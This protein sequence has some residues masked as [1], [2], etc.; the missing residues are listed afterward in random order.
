MEELKKKLYRSNSLP[1]TDKE[2]EA[3]TSDTTSFEGFSRID[4]ETFESH[5]FSGGVAWI[6]ANL[7][8]TQEEKDNYEN[9]EIN[10]LEIRIPVNNDEVERLHYKKLEEE[11]RASRSQSICFTE[12]E[13]AREKNNPI[14]SPELIVL[15]PR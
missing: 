8:K 2:L 11:R 4:E 3:L 14:P 7:E 5:N 9:H 6:P 10:G 12:L 15:V 13:C 1:I